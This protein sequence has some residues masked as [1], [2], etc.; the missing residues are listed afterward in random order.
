[1]SPL[2]WTC[3]CTHTICQRSCYPS[4]VLCMRTLTAAG[5]LDGKTS[6]KFPVTCGVRQGCVLAPTLFKLYFDVA[7]HIALDEHQ[8]Q[9]KDIKVAHLHD[10]NLVGNRKILK[11]E[12]LVTNL[13][14]ADDMALLADDLT[15][16]TSMLETLFTCFKKLGLS[17]SCEKTKS[18]A[19]L[20][21]E[22]PDAQ[23]PATIPLK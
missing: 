10:A 3:A 22:S 13:E 4:S 5:R 2:S 12:T 16:L 8:L 19:V 20:P 17:I 18:L 6:K 9:G 14:Y 1:M 7:I 15:D 23:S 21:S 11:L